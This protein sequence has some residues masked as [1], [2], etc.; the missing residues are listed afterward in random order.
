VATDYFTKWVEA[1][2][3]KKATSKFVID[4]LMNNVVTRFGCPKRIVSEN[5]M[6]FR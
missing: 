3:T 2:P 5:A 4:F 1:I 6:C